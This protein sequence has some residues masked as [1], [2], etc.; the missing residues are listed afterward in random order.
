MS[1]HGGMNPVDRRQMPHPRPNL[2][3]TRTVRTS[4]GIETPPVE[5]M[6]LTLIA[7]NQS[8][9]TIISTERF[10]PFAFQPIKTRA[11]GAH[12]VRI[13]GASSNGPRDFN[14]SDK[15]SLQFT[16]KELPFI[17]A[18]LMGWIPKVQFVA[19]GPN[20]DKGVSLEVQDGPRSSSRSG[21]KIVASVPFLSPRLRS[22]L[23]L[24]CF[25]SR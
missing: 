16:I 6:P 5:R 19:H 17:L 25:S 8:T 4:P 22:S 1:G 12:T 20:N 13:E 3:Q 23:S 24:T 21:R 2:N 15:I 9:R 10:C 11:K 7:P 14:W 18:V